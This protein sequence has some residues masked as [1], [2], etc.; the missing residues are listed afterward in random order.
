MVASLVGEHR[1][2]A[3]GLQQL[4]HAGTVVMDCGLKS[5]GSVVVAHGLSC[6]MACGI[7]PDQGSN[8]CPLPWQ[9]G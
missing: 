2:W 6:P 9:A 3:C 1:P 5:T 7:F 4:Q 8:L